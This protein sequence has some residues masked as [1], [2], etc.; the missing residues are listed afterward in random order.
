MVDSATIILTAGKGGDGIVSFRR[1]KYV[2]RGGPDGGDGGNGADIYFCVNKQLSTLVDYTRLK[3]IKAKNGNPGGTNQR[4]GKDGADLFLDVP[5]G[6]QIFN[7]PSE[8]GKWV[9]Q[10]DLVEDGSKVLIA[11]GGRGGWGNVHFATAVNQAPMSANKGTEGETKE[12]KLELKLIADV[13][14]I[15]LPNA[16]KSALISAISNCQPKIA[17]YPFT[18]LEPNLGVVTHK[19][20][21][22]VVADIPGLI[23]GASTGKGLGDKFLRH[24]ERTTILVHLISVEDDDIERS[25]QTIRAE[26]NNFQPDLLNK[27]EI[28]V[29]NKADLLPQKSMSKFINKHSVQVISAVTRQ[30][31]SELLDTIIEKLDE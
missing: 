28:I 12:L 3:T 25:Y 23:E 6:T 14:I 20:K 16:G 4:H 29:I 27:I 26:L 8:S 15:G 11:K 24:I 21:T 10:F 5:V 19:G 1:E 30:G 2:P 7:R 13:G 17:N 18:T 31:V 9:S 22:F